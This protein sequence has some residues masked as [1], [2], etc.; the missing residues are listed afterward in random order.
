MPSARTIVS[1]ATFLY[2]G[3]AD[4]ASSRWERTGIP[5]A[6]PGAKLTTDL[7]GI[8]AAVDHRPR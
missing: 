1:L 8:T 3:W 6:A 7:P 5:T 4:V 2:R